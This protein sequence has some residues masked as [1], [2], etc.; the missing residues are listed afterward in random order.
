M[1]RYRLFYRNWKRAWLC[2]WAWVD[3]CFWDSTEETQRKKTTTTATT[4]IAVSASG[5]YYIPMYN[6][7]H[8]HTEQSEIVNSTIQYHFNMCSGKES[9]HFIWTHIQ[10]RFFD[11]LYL[12]H[13]LCWFFLFSVSRTYTHILIWEPLRTL[14]NWKSMLLLFPL[15]MLLLLLLSTIYSK[16]PKL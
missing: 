9:H 2:L 15:S 11:Y 5:E 6:T 16:S 10:Q 4:T 14:V 7:I 8:K 3:R 12:F 13:P 1:L